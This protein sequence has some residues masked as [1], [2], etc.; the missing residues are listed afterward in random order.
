MTHRWNRAGLLAAG[1]I[2]GFVAAAPAAVAA[3]L[4]I[5]GLSIMG[6]GPSGQS[7][8]YSYGENST[9]AITNSQSQVNVNAAFLATGGLNS[10]PAYTNGTGL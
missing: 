1:S 7:V 4:T 3:P 6:A 9:G 2:A 5:E 10:L 8:G